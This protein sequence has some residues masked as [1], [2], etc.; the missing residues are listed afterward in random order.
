MEYLLVSV[1][2]ASHV[3]PSEKRGWT[4]H[5]PAQS[6]CM[7]ESFR[8]QV[9]CFVRQHELISARQGDTKRH[10]TMQDDARRRNQ[11]RAATASARLV[12][13]SD[14]GVIRK[15]RQRNVGHQVI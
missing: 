12:K 4:G 7:Y 11:R 8:S 6:F 3:K 5:L 10:K 2:E 13:R 15:E 1:S 9:F 14:A